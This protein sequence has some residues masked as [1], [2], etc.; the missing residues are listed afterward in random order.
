MVMAPGCQLY[1]GHDEGDDGKNSGVADDDDAVGHIC[2][3]EWKRGVVLTY[4]SRA[5]MVDT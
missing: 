3:D 1:V 4:N 2:D 5:C